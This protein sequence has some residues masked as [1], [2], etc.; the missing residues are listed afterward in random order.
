[1]LHIMTVLD[2]AK[3]TYNKQGRI[4]QVALDKQCHPSVC[5]RRPAR[6]TV[7]VFPVVGI[8]FMAIAMVLAVKFWPALT[9]SHPA[10][11]DLKVR[12]L[13][14]CPHRRA[15]PSQNAQHFQHF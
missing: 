4:R 3:N 14:V 5:R 13:K 7:V 12:Q 9:E 1:M 15:L 10:S 8:T 11:G 2:T 6:R